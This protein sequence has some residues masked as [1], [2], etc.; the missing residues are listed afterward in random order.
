MYIYHVWRKGGLQVLSCI[1]PLL[2]SFVT[3]SYPVARLGPIH[4]PVSVSDSTVLIN[5]DVLLP[6]SYMYAGDLNSGPQA[7]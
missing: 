1:T 5:I 6:N 2:Y 3:T 7:Q 4:P